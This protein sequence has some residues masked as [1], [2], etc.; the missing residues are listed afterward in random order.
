[1]TTN[2]HVAAVKRGKEPGLRTGLAQYGVEVY[3]PEIVVV[4]RGRKLREPLFPSYVF[5]HLDPGSELWPQI[6]WA[7]GIRYFLGYERQPTPVDPHLVEDIKAR[8]ERWNQGG[9]E[10]ALRS[11]QNVRITSGSLSG[12]EAVFCRYLSGRQRCEVLV[13]LI[14]RPHTVQIPATCVE[15]TKPA[16]LLA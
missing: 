11:G 9:W 1:M 2:W 4:K 6:R 10:S 5:C 12:L 13:S 14:G 15:I 16:S 8:V 3:S 7:Q